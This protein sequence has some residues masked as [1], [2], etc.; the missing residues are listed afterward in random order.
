MKLKDYMNRLE[1]ETE[2]VYISTGQ[3]WM[4]CGTKPEYDKY[5]GELNEE[6]KRSLAA[7]KVLFAIQYGKRRLLRN[8]VKGLLSRW[9]M[10]TK[11]IL[12]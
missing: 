6:M 5:I 9:V 7:R 10:P 11:I 8:M 2:I 1:S 4:F 12:A 3:C